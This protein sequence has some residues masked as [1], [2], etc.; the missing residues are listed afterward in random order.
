[1]L[2][3]LAC[4]KKK[5]MRTFSLTH[6]SSSGT[7]RHYTS[8]VHTAPRVHHLDQVFV[9]NLRHRTDRFNFIMN[10]LRDAAIPRDIITHYPAVV[11]AHI[12]IDKVIQ[13]GFVSALGALRLREPEEHHVWGMDLNL[14]ALGC[15]LSHIDIWG[16]VAALRLER[17]LIVEDDSIFC[18]NFLVEYEHVLRN[19]PGGWELL[20]LSGLDTEGKGSRLRVND[21]IRLVPRMHR[22]TNCYLL[23]HRGARSLLSKCLPLTYQLD[24]QMTLNHEMHPQLHEAYVTI[25]VC[26]S[27]YPQLVVQATRFGSDIQDVSQ[28][29]AEGE[30]RS[31][32]LAAGWPTPP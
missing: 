11:G 4:P 16:K 21:R 22:T 25:P 27:A 13:S 3:E 32:M 7:G 2:N 6:G 24:T 14:G 29:S 15:A 17:A 12:S 20:Y 19:C 1:M 28:R 10:Q 26:Y 31:R 8:S 9:I 18:P 23:N 30:E 5:L